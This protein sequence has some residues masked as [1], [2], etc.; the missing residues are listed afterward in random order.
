MAKRKRPTNPLI[1]ALL[2]AARSSPF[3]AGPLAFASLFGRKRGKQPRPSPTPSPGGLPGEF[4]RLAERG[5]IE[6]ARKRKVLR[7]LGVEQRDR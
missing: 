7:D 3:T 5:R 1:R 4:T 6:Q 2:G